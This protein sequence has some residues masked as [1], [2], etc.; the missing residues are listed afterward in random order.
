MRRPGAGLHGDARRS[1]E[2]WCPR[3]NRLKLLRKDLPLIGE[4]R[5]A[6]GVEA[7]PA[8]GLA[9]REPLGLRRRPRRLSRAALLGAAIA[10]VGVGPG[11]LGR[12]RRGPVRPL[13]ARVLVRVAEGRRVPAGGITAATARLGQDE[14]RDGAADEEQTEDGWE[15]HLHPRHVTPRG[16]ARVVTRGGSAQPPAGR[17][18]RRRAPSRAPGLPR[19]P[20]S[21]PRYGPEPLPP[22]RFQT[23]AVRGALD[24]RGSSGR[25]LEPAWIPPDLPPPPA[26][27][28]RSSRG[29][30]A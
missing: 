14:E 27:R 25:A 6:P 11:R 19:A 29:R 26:Q 12:G 22:V 5:A 30:M 18:R 9:V 10:A 23:V 20:S 7:P 2:G 28:P 17:A 13:P 1:Q 8:S 15:Q 4:G 24:R 3:C 21:S 16:G